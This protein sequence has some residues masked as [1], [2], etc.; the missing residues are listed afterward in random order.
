MAFQMKELRDVMLASKDIKLITA[1]VE[2]SSD[3]IDDGIILAKDPKI[4]ALAAKAIAYKL[5]G[6]TPE[7][8]VSLVAAEAMQETLISMIDK[9]KK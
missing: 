2:I 6:V 3:A 8:I 5:N 7:L 9:N 1:E 4:R